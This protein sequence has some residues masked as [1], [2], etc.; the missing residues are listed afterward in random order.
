MTEQ[1]NKPKW[2]KNKAVL[3]LLGL[4][5]AGAGAVGYDY[6][7][8]KAGEGKRNE[9]LEQMLEARFNLLRNHKNFTSITLGEL[10]L[11][12]TAFGLTGNKIN[13]M[14]HNNGIILQAKLNGFLG[15][16]DVECAAGN[17]G[18]RQ[19]YIRARDAGMRFWRDPS[20]RLV[21]VK[22]HGHEVM[23][24]K[25]ISLSSA[26]GITT[27]PEMTTDNKEPVVAKNEESFVE[28]AY[29][30]TI[31]LIRGEDGGWCDEHGRRYDPKDVGGC[32]FGIGDKRDFQRFPIFNE[33]SGNFIRPIKSIAPKSPK[34]A[35]ND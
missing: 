24:L 23:G 22:L 18:S 32:V 1:S 19:D 13:L 29:Y 21:Q 14:V 11:L 33:V 7:Q 30:R 25:P 5:V 6:W 17:D 20:G 31:L 28:K 12:Q 15:D 4:T 26:E 8:A 16:I 3:G 34:Q 27:W 9:I 35:E 2:Y 10:Q